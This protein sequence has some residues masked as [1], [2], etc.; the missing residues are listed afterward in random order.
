MDRAMKKNLYPPGWLTFNTATPPTHNLVEVVGQVHWGVKMPSFHIGGNVDVCKEEGGCAAIIDSGT[1]LIAAPRSVLG[2]MR[3]FFES[4]KEDCSNMD[5]LPNMVFELGSGGTMERFEL[6]PA[7]YVMRITS[8]GV[9]NKSIWDW[10]E[11][12]PRVQVT[13]QCI[14]AFMPLDKHSQFGPVFILGMSF[15]RYYKTTYVRTTSAAP[16]KMYFDAV[17]AT[18]NAVGMNAAKAAVAFHSE[19]KK[20][21]K[22]TALL[23]GAAEHEASLGSMW[24]NRAEAFTPLEA[25]EDAIEWY[26]KLFWV[27][28]LP[29]I[30]PEVIGGFQA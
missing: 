13:H 26:I 4:I 30:W 14:P 1:S 20:G 22:Q 15:L 23:A 19:G 27:S 16:A 17:D 10:L 6:P 29:I 5:Q 3:P 18:C 7:A 8:A 25:D 2:K 12:R 9:Q 11:G 24:R 21:A 28:I